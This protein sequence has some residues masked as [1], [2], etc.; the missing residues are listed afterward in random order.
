VGVLKVTDK[1]TWFVLCQTYHNVI[2][3]E[4]TLA[5]E[6]MVIDDAR[7]SKKKHPLTAILKDC[8]YQ[9]RQLAEQ[10]ALTPNSR[11]RLGVQVK[12]PDID[13]EFLALLD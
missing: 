3:A 12:S 2:E 4:E 1:Q 6:G 13:E 10:F 5:V 8:R 9:F 11:E 7:G